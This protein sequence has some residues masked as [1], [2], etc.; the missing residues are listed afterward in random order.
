MCESNENNIKI[1]WKNRAPSSTRYCRPIGFKIKKE[2]VQNVKEA[3][4]EI[5]SQ[6]SLIEPTITILG[7]KE[8]QFK[9]VPI[10]IMLDAD[11]QHFDRDFI[12]PS[13]QCL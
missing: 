11:Y 6:I 3:Y 1:F 8:I 12:F 9:R 2:N 13:M 10:C 5:Q 7:A 4:N